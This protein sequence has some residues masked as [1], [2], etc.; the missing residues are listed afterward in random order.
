[1]SAQQKNT[2]N[3]R[4]KL[5]I[6]SGTFS[7]F[8]IRQGVGVL[9]IPY[10]QM[11]LAVDPFLLAAAM[12][13]PMLLASLLG[14]WVG[15]FS[16]T[17]QQKY[18]HRRPFIVFGALIT[19]ICYGAIWQVPVGW[20][21]DNQILYFI[22]AYSL[23]CLAA[24]FF[25]IPYTCLVYEATENSQERV[26]LLAL[27]SIV[28]KVCSLVYQ[29][30][31]PL[32]QMSI[33]GSLFMGIKWVGWGIAIIF[34]ALAGMLPAFWQQ[35]THATRSEYVPAS[36]PPRDLIKNLDLVLANPAFVLLLLI[37]FSQFFISVFAASMDY[38]L[39][40]YYMQTGD[41]TEGAYWKG[42]L[43][44][45]YA[46]FGLLAVPLILKLVASCGRLNGFVIVYVIT[47]V[48]GAVKWFVFTPGA[49]YWL[50][51]DA[52]LGCIVW[53]SMAI[54]LHSLVADTAA[55]RT[56]HATNLNGVY[57]SVHNIVTQICM[58]GA[59]L[60]S[61]FTL[62][63]IGFDAQLA[64]QQNVSTISAMRVILSI[65]TVLSALLAIFAIFRLKNHQNLI[66]TAAIT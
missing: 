63:Q 47:A 65:G 2:L 12:M 54:L 49:E 37:T 42:I 52:M 30:A 25:L 36:R 11:T 48:G 27:N 64:G 66:E 59:M 24:E 14:P 28:G 51:L 34:I 10:Y 60:I 18:G 19:A 20:Q 53:A 26:N 8:F 62:N 33:F 55:N 5:M 16:D 4:D 31:F 13:I 44:T 21:G 35:S 50:L 43:S 56:M 39:I 29:W 7:A 41:L 1:M 9:A 46:G 40:V 57:V 17:Y 6:S 32:A 38:Y 61:G 3:L 58:S 45:A 23:F 22:F 15:Q